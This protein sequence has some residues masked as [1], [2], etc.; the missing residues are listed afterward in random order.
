MLTVL[1]RMTRRNAEAT[2]LACAPGFAPRGGG[3]GAG[4]R[5]RWRHQAVDRRASP[6]SPTPWPLRRS[7][8]CTSRRPTVGDASAKIWDCDTSMPT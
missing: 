3:C 7:G 1:A 5:M 4:V 8:S 2:R 6:R